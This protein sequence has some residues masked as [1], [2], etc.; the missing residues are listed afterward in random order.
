V[1]APM[2]LVRT[3]FSFPPS[4]GSSYLVLVTG[5]SP[6]PWFWARLR[7]FGLSVSTFYALYRR[8]LSLFGH[9]G[10]DSP[11]DACGLDSDCIN[12][13]TQVE[14]LPDDCRCRSYC[15]NQR[16]A[17]SFLLSFPPFTAFRSITYKKNCSLIFAHI[18]ALMISQ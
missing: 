12:R 18:C 13:L 4:F 11:G 2:N 10:V 7:S 3:R 6:F 9:T 16:L 1:I 15:Q 14:C 8:H 17:P 5:I